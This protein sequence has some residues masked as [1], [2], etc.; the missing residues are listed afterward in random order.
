MGGMI[1]LF[2][3]HPEIIAPVNIRS[4]LC[5]FLISKTSN[6]YLEKYR[7]VGQIVM[8][9]QISAF[10]VTPIMLLMIYLYSTIYSYLNLIE[11]ITILISIVIVNMKFIYNS[12]LII[13]KQ[14]V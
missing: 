10:P 13:E 6:A 11:I 4:M 8:L 3:T 5:N 7:R 14:L 12:K 2:V 1:Q 9:G